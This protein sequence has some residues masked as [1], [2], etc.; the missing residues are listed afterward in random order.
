MSL[1]KK[2]DG[3]TAAGNSGKTTTHRINGYILGMV[4]LFILLFISLIG[5]LC[6]F[7]WK[8]AP[9]LVNSP[10]NG[11][12]A[13]LNQSV[14]RGDITSS[15]GTVIAFSEVNDGKEIRKYPYD[16]AFAHV[17][18]YTNVG[19]AGLESTAGYYL[20]NSH[21]S[22]WSK[23]YKEITDQKVTGDTVVT[24]L[25]KDL[26]QL[27]SDAM[28]DYQGA[29]V[30]MEP[31]TGKIRAMVSKP[32]FN[33]N[34][35]EADYE[36][37]VSD[38]SNSNLVNRATKGLY[39]PGSTFK[40]VTALAFMEQNPD[41]WTNYQYNCEGSIQIGDQVIHCSHNTKHGKVDLTKSIAKS[42]NSS[43]VNIGV[44]L[45][46]AQF[47]E[48][49]ERLMFNQKLNT[50][51]STAVSK[52]DLTPESSRALV[53]QTSFGQG[54]TLITPLQNAMITSAIANL[55]VMMN[56]QLLDRVV[57]T[58]GSVV[59][60]YEPESL[61]SVM[62]AEQAMTLSEMMM[63]TVNS[64]TAKVLKS[65]GYQAAAKT[66][67]AQTDDEKETDAWMVAFAPADNPQYVVSMVLEEA[68]AGS[69]TAGPIIKKIFDT[70]LAD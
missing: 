27:I 13:K 19:E 58:D 35:L 29:C 33:P 6:Y 48:T 64:G 68:G 16:E 50:G 25:D 30:V 40:L 46:I 38:Q 67:S 44:S 37:L 43:F 28:G 5:Y 14:V 12:L 69:E 62:T 63:E 55:G 22:A 3:K 17:V 23:L 24:N 42:C 41:D 70:L 34:T 32:D 47:R 8:E 61:G 4:Y 21:E 59:E 39:S 2:K 15:D 10:Y 1:W 36:K 9:D 56:P 49:A 53:M 60:T 54:N 26:Q 51:F 11:R 52:F 57:S 7:T 18:G 65:S 66:G 45:D 20:L 31:S